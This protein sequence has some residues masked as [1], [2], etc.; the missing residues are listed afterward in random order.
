MACVDFYSEEVQELLRSEVPVV[1]IDHVCDGRISVLS[2]NVQGME[3]LL[4]YI[5][6]QGHRKIAYI[7]GDDTSVT[8]KRLSSFYR[9]M[10]REGIQVPDEYVRPARYLDAD[11]SARQTRELLELKD[12][13]TCILYPDDL[14]A[15]GGFNEIRERDLKIPE[16]ISIAGYDGNNIARIM[17]PKLTTLCQDTSAIGRIAA[18]KLVEL[19]EQPKTALIRSYT[20][21]GTLFQGRS[22]KKLG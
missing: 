4:E 18:E 8:K 22:V 6:S 19:I 14:S 13:P 17:E 12:P 20:V 5:F 7:Y 15:V 16:D 2:N 9:M 10:Q 1:T 21:D 11:L 3:K